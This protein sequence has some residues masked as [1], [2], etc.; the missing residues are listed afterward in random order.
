TFNGYT[1]RTHIGKGNQN[2]T[3][4]KGSTAVK[5]PSNLTEQLALE[6]V[7]SNPQGKPIQN[8]IMTDPRWPA[9]EGWIKMSQDVA[10]SKGNIHIHY[11]YNK[12][13]NIFDDFK[14]K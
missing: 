9:S 8:F 4:S 7:E 12:I 11:L 2:I 6:Q 5:Q 10:T 14:L 1:P 3:F 13:F